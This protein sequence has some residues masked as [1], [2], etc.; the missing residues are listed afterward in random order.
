[1]SYNPIRFPPPHPLLRVLQ[2][3]SLTSL[4]AFNV[5]PTTTTRMHRQQFQIAAW[6]YVWEFS[7]ASCSSSPFAC[8]SYFAAADNKPTAPTTPREET[9]CPFVFGLIQLSRS[10]SSLVV[11]FRHSSACL[12]FLLSPH[13]SNWPTSILM[14]IRYI[15]HFCGHTGRLNIS[16]PPVTSPREV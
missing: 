15:F 13:P 11:S 1:M 14:P 8:W 3:F 12:P 5:C 6:I 16:R 10:S 9:L 2:S 7:A 4:N